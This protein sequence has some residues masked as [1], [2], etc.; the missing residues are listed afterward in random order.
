[1]SFMPKHFLPVNILLSTFN[2]ER[3]LRALLD[4]LLSQKYPNIRIFIRD[5]G[6]TDATSDILRAYASNNNHISLL[7]GNNI[8]V[9]SSFMTL[10]QI[11]KN[12]EGYFAFCDQDDVWGK[13]KI[14][15][16][17]STIESYEEPASSLYFSR[18]AL[19]SQDGTELHL[20]DVPSC[21]SFNN[22]LVENV[23]TGATTL[24]GCRIRDIM[25][26]GH[27]DFMVWHDWWLYLVAAAFGRVIYDK[28]PTLQYRRHSL[29][30]TNFRVPSSEGLPAKINAFKRAM[31]RKR[32]VHPFEQAS[33][34]KTI[35]HS[36]LTQHQLWLVGKIEKVYQQ[37]NLLNRIKFACD[38]DFVIN[39]DFDDLGFRVLVLLGRI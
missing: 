14:A 4:S 23:V 32:R 35:Y 21:L 18:L 2:G 28:E 5:D 20:S 31:R 13:D 27:P 8:G 30:L 34:F 25:L 11:Q 38:R 9:V 7:C 22:A 15:R 10:L 37:R 3:Y 36:L 17:V 24:F 29:T 1:M 6:S 12:A 16:A 19:V 39:N 26:M 33:H